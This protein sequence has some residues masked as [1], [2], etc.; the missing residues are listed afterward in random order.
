MVDRAKQ[1]QRK[2]SKV[3]ISRHEPRPIISM[4]YDMAGNT[5]LT[6]NEIVGTDTTDITGVGGVANSSDWTSAL[7]YLLGDERGTHPATGSS[8]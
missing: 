6:S 7:V 1:I 2:A 8:G 4:G 3:L 5:R